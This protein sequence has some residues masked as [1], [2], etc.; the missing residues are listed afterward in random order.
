M[1]YPRGSSNLTGA[2]RYRSGFRGVLILQVE[3]KVVA[4]M[5]GRLAP[6]VT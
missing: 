3:E 1:P 4:Y 5:E 2:T 6:G